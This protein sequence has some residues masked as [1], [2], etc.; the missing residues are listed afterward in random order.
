[1]TLA[2][3]L[4]PKLAAAKADEFQIKITFGRKEDLTIQ[5]EPTWVAA[6]NCLQLPVL[7]PAYFFTHFI[8]Q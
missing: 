6:Y 7:W 8:N 4:E 1:M 3:V 2:G 5:A